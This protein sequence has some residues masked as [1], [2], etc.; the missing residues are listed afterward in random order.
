MEPLGR[1]EQVEPALAPGDER[2]AQGGPVGPVA[3]S[4]E[5]RRGVFRPPLPY[6]RGHQLRNPEIGDGEDPGVRVQHGTDPERRRRMPVRA[7]H[8]SQASRGLADRDPGR[9]AVPVPDQIGQ[10]LAAAGQVARHGVHGVQHRVPPGGDFAGQILAA[11]EKLPDRAQQRDPEY[12]GGAVLSGAH[13]QDYGCARQCGDESQ[14]GRPRLQRVRV[15]HLGVVQG[16]VPEEIIDRLLVQQPRAEQR[17]LLEQ[18]LGLPLHDQAEP[19]HFLGAAGEADRP[20]GFRA[21]DDRQ[22]DAGL[23][24]AQSPGLP[25]SVGLRLPGAQHLVGGLVHGADPALVPAAD[26]DRLLVGD[27]HVEAG[28]PAGIDSDLLGE[29]RRECWGAAVLVHVRIVQKLPSY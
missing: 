24:A 14:L 3:Q 8:A 13:V 26:D 1:P 9:Q 2:L 11:A 6:R 16:Y 20:D 25:G 15:H 29:L 18:E 10:Q 27:Q 4:A 17:R 21:D 5:Y 22:A 7:V 19:A 28:N 23:D 12:R